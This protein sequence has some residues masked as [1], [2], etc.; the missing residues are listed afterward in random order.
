MLWLS[1][2]GWYDQTSPTIPFALRHLGSRLKAANEEK[3]IDTREGPE[4][5]LTKFLTKFLKAKQA[6]PEIINERTVLGLSLS[7]VSAG[8]DTTAIT[9]S[10]LFYYLLKFP[11]SFCKL[12]EELNNHL[13]NNPADSFKHIIG[14]GEAQ[15]LPYLD[16]C[17][18]ETFR[19]HPALSVLLERKVP[20]SGATICGH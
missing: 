10:A 5:L 3:N 15:K 2:H 7:T 14:W 20:Q 4:D 16:A 1:K 18:K 9:L 17:I 19:I 11:A 8:G 13:P 6:N 12:Q